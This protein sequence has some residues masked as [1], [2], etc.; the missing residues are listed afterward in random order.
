M[1]SL[2]RNTFLNALSLF[3]LTQLISG[4]NISGGFIAF[5]LAGFCLT[6]LFW[7]LKP[8]LNLI[9]LPLNA[10][11][12]GF[13]SVVTNAIL[14]YLLTVFI[15]NVSIFAFTFPGFSFAG[16]IVPK[17]FINTFFAFIVIACL[18]SLLFTFFKWVFKK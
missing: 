8:V 7:I 12:L 17:I 11:T 10:L 5:V 9:S 6:I 18:Q 15:P 16:F 2:L 4:I 3:L 14:F 13:F 1:K